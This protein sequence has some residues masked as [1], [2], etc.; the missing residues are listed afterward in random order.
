IHLKESAI[1]ID[2]EVR[3][4]CDF[5]GFDP[6]YFAN[7][8]KMVVVCNEDA[9]PVVQEFFP[10]AVVIG[11]VTDVTG[12]AGVAGIAGITKE[13]NNIEAKSKN[14]VFMEVISGG[15]RRLSPLES[16]QLPRIC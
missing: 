1:P 2:R 16:T 15:I 3:A 6:L 7:E 8:G 5:L 9:V 4:V 10:E 13:E 14:G 12:I 11:S